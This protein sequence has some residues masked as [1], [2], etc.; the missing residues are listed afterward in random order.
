V[1][2]LPIRESHFPTASTT[3]SSHV[4]GGY[5]IGKRSVDADRLPVISLF[6]SRVQIRLQK[7]DTNRPRF[8]PPLNKNYWIYFMET[9]SGLVTTVC[10]KDEDGL[11]PTEYR[12]EAQT[13]LQLCL[14]QSRSEIHET[15]RYKP[16][17]GGVSYCLHFF[18]SLHFDFPLHATLHSE[19]QKFDAKRCL[20]SP[21]PLGSSAERTSRHGSDHCGRIFHCHTEH[22]CN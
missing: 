17:S 22:F 18:T 10:R 5:G 11:L 2:L 20:V 13:L 9:R 12:M 6:G 21:L 4:T 16:G 19:L 15:H 8:R 14:G 7:D 3:I 1:T